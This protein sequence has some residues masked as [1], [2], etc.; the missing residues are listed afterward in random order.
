[1][2]YAIIAVGGKQ[3]IVEE[4]LEFRLERQD[5]PKAEV[6]YY[7]D[8][9]TT[10]IGAPILENVEVKLSK[11]EDYTKKTDIFRFKSKSR[12]R[13]RKG[14]KQPMSVLKVDSIKYTADSKAASKS[15]KEDK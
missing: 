9:R 10:Q 14:H 8:G 3:F 13:R 15:A 6:L 7:K 2:K 12:Y 11:V 4:G 5:N 1:M